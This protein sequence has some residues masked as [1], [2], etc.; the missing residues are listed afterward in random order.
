MT[1]V[2]DDL[3]QMWK[4][5]YVLFDSNYLLEN[6]EEAWK[7]YWDKAAK[8]YGEYASK[9]PQILDM[10]NIATEIIEA[11]IKREEQQNVEKVG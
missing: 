10:I 4:D 7:A 1:N 8:I 11:R 9:Y 2:P 3:R 5:V 6:T